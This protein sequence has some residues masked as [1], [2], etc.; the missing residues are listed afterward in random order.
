MAFTTA[1]LPGKLPTTFEELC[2][3]HWPRPIHDEI[4]FR[5]S[6]RIVDRLATLANLTEGQ[7]E[8]L[9]TLTTLMEAYESSSSPIETGNL[10][11]VEALRYL[12]E[13]RQMSASD[14]GRVLGNRSLGAAIL[15]G[16][17]EISKANAVAIARH[18][19]VSPSLF[20]TQ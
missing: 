17:R 2:K 10:D 3:L 14:L 19:C 15:R 8:Y 16:D 13:G 18:F 5:N 4:G 12:V 6:Q 1:T 9:E 11:P 7:E 20:I